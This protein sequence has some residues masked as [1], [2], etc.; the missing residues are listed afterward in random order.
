[1]G[2]DP[3]VP[4][5]E[6]RGPRE[7]S[8]GG[9]LFHVLHV[10]QSTYG[11]VAAYVRGVIEDQV[12]RGWRVTLVSPMGSLQEQVREGARGLRA[13]LGGE[14]GSG[15]V[16]G[17]RGALPAPAD[18]GDTAGPDPSPLVE[19]RLGRATRS[20][21][22]RGADPV[23]AAWLVV[24]ICRRLPAIDVDV[25]G[26]ARRADVPTDHLRQRGRT[27]AG[28]AGRPQGRDGGRPRRCV[29]GRRVGRPD[30]GASFG[31]PC[32]IWAST[33]AARRLCRTHVRGRRAKTCCWPRGLGSSSGSRRRTWSSSGKAP[34][35]S[36]FGCAQD[37][38]C[39][40]PACR[41]TCSRG[42]RS[43]SSSSRPRD[44]RA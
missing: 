16:R 31:P 37:R 3:F 4:P 26:T 10:T 33:R 9:H 14:E 18:E 29:H 24:R 19:G 30:R 13:R 2:S 32:R 44:G 1:M 7:S 36:G 23:P 34:S 21:G 43:G 17:A 22:T 20:D 41:R 11:G 40:S 27:R 12:D 38:A 15:A 28:T 39:S 25:L 42:C 35:T 6:R 5:G 8:L